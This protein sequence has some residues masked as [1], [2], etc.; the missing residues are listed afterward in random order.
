MVDCHQVT[1]SSRP[2]H[3]SCLY[4]VAINN[5]TLVHP[6]HKLY[7][8]IIQFKALSKWNYFLYSN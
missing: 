7:L 2:N 5:T 4:M 8:K 6:N 1:N 3:L